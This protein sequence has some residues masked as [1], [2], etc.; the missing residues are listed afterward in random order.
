MPKLEIKGGIKKISL[1][2]IIESG[3]VRETYT[4]IEEL[5]E[6]IKVHGQ[7]QPV[8]VKIRGKNSDD[9]DEYELVA[10]HRRIRAFQYLCDKGDDFSR[11]DSVVVTG[12]KLTL[13]LIE[14]LQRSNLTS[15]ER[16][17]GIYEMTQ[18]GKIS[19]ND[20]AAILGKDRTYI[21]R[22]IKAYEVRDLCAKKGIDTS[23]ITTWTLHE[24][25]SAGDSDIP[26][27]IERIKA[28]GGTVSAARLVNKEYRGSIS[29]KQ[30]ASGAEAAKQAIG[31]G[32][33]TPEPE[34]KEPDIPEFLTGRHPPTPFQPLSPPLVVK[35]PAH[36]AP[37][38]KSTAHAATSKSTRDSVQHMEVDIDEVFSL[39]GDYIED[40]ERTVAGS[41]LF[42]KT[43]AANDI[44]SWL[45]ERAFI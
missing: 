10:G 37:V 43:E 36:A 8:L 26:L 18:H 38:P 40:L 22:N 42:Y 27:L 29:E 12:D 17:R 19:H 33:E 24:I 7:L 28:A 20:V 16:E 31:L 13:Q 44:I 30:E 35:A 5:A 34:I 11:I 15:T 23:E 25:S 1:S 45:S 41:E 2:Q 3:N 39:I 4:D 6:S 9:I 14:N 32:S 21:T